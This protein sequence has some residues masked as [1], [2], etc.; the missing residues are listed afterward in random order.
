MICPNCHCK[1][2]SIKI[3]KEERTEKG[4]K[5]S[6]QVTWLLFRRCFQQEL[7]CNAKTSCSNHYHCVTSEQMI[8]R[9]KKVLTLLIFHLWILTLSINMVTTV[10][11][12]EGKPLLWKFFSIKDKREYVIAIIAIMSTCISHR[13]ACSQVGLSHM[14]YTC[15]KKVIEKVDTLKNGATFVPCKRNGN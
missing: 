4:F 7:H 15:F 8:M 12:T 14:Y 3:G 10:V 5:K 9:N 13:Q 11:T 6:I 1:F 2:L